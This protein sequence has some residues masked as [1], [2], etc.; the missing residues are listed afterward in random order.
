M[1]K[2]NK[3]PLEIRLNAIIG[4]LSESLLVQEKIT[5]KSIFQALNRAGLT[6]SEIGNIFGKSR[7]DI[8]SVLTRAK[9]PKRTKN[10]GPKEERND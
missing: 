8:G 6:P 4:L 5:Q 3:D 9:K 2:E 10:L 1:T 7:S